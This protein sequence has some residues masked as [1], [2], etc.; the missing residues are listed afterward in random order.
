MAE[1]DED[2][3]SMTNRELARK[4]VRHWRNGKRF[5]ETLTLADRIEAA[6]DATE[7]D[8]AIKVLQLVK[9]A[10]N[11]WEACHVELNRLRAKQAKERGQ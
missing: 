5:G 4:V 7:L 11:T 9:D 3:G 6:L 8:S 2:R 1:V 10:S